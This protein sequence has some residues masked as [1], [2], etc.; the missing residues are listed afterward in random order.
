MTS[1]K[2]SYPSYQKMVTVAL[3]ELPAYPGQ[4][5]SRIKIKNYMNKMYNV[6]EA[7]LKR[8]LSNALD[9]LTLDGYLV[10]V[11]MSYRLSPKAKQQNKKKTAAKK[12]TK[13]KTATKG[14]KARAKTQY[15]WIVF[16]TLPHMQAEP[17]GTFSTETKALN[18]VVELTT[19]NER[20]FVTGL[21]KTRAAAILK[22]VE[23]TKKSK[24]AADRNA[25][26]AKLLEQGFQVLRMKINELSIYD[27]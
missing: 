1:K 19:D 25:N 3:T 15:V 10:K 13:K 23:A 17:F 24:K 18:A 5:I 6:A 2:K 27:D 9:R 14:S 4:S 12:E 26:L 21:N 8:Y 7:N 11:K 16:G 22:T 20:E